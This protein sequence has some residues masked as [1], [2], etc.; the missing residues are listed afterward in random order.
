MGQAHAPLSPL[1]HFYAICLHLLFVP[2]V[3][4]P[5]MAIEEAWGVGHC[6][7]SRTGE[8]DR[9]THLRGSP[10]YSIRGLVGG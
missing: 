5:H 4:G 8:G 10:P 6:V 1:T 2:L 3:H 7:V 9:W